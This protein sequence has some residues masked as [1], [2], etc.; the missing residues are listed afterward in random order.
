MQ[1]TCSALATALKLD[2][3]A[4]AVAL[5]DSVRAMPDAP[6]AQLAATIEPHVRRHLGGSTWRLIAAM[7]A[8]YVAG[9]LRV[10]HSLAAVQNDTYDEATVLLVNQVCLHTAAYESHVFTILSCV[11]KRV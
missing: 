9:R 3:Q 1:P 6:A 10:E 2:Q 4:A 11:R 5:E 7:E 8:P